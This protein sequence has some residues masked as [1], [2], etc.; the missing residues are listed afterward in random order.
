M[1]YKFREIWKTVV[2]Y[3]VEHPRYQVSNL[4]RVKCLDWRKIGKKKMCKLYNN[5]YG[6]FTLNIDGKFVMVSRLVAEAFIPNPNNKPEVDH[7]DTNR[8]NNCVWNLRWATKK[9]N[10]NN[11]LSL[12]HYSENSAHN[13]YWLGKLGAEH[14]N[15]IQIVQL[16]LNRQFIKKWACSYEVEREL[17]INHSGIIACCRGRQKTAGGF[18][19]M[20]YYDWLKTRRKKSLKDIKPLFV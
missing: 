16:T 14:P 3:G 11:P 5:G 4:G 15:S 20:Y 18:R 13:K 8:Q 2:I 6:Y 19:W 10:R 9:E 7:V 12:K 1:I 17:G